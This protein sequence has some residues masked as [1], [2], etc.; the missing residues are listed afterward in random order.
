MLGSFTKCIYID[1][2][3]T[4]AKILTPSTAHVTQIFHDG[5]I[6]R[7]LLYI[8][9]QRDCIFMPD[10]DGL[11]G[12]GDGLFAVA[13]PICKKNLPVLKIYK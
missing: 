3:S 9:L 11:M 13:V 10:V 12:L 5:A 1:Y 8:A 4:A 7:V 2:K 6:A